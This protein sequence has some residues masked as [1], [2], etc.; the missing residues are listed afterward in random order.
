MSPHPPEIPADR[1]LAGAGT[2]APITL[3]ARLRTLAAACLLVFGLLVALAV[4]ARLLF[5]QNPSGTDFVE[6][7]AQG[8]LLAQHA[9]PF[10][11]A[12]TL[13]IEQSLGQN[14]PIPQI[15]FSPPVALWFTLPLGHLSPRAGLNLWRAAQLASLALALWLLWRLNG[16][17]ASKWHLLGFV[18]A[19]VIAC[20]MAAQLSL[21]FLL[22]L[23]VFL[24]H[25]R[26]HPFWAGAVL[27][28][29]ALK[30]HIILPFALVLLLWVVLRRCYWLAAGFVAALAVSCAVSL[31]LAPHCWAQYRKAMAGSGVM[32]VF[33][34]A[35]AC[36]LRFLIDPAAKWIQ[37]VPEICACI[38]ALWY[39]W[40]RRGNWEW[41]RHGMMV[42]MVA[43]ICTPYGWFVD[44]SI[45]LP[46]MLTSV[47]CALQYRRSLLPLLFFN[48]AALAEAL[49]SLNLHSHAYLWTAPAWLAWYLY[50]TR[51]PRRVPEP[52]AAPA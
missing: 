6:Y 31:Y 9:N 47:Y 16:R 27:M 40:T 26:Q 3:R 21:F 34:P 48:A 45:L 1:P 32:D 51:V 49:A 28:P 15:T 23:V 8:R 18:F 37:F 25:H 24:L 13:R 10:D 11:P 38:W 17:P 41:Q 30:P 35:L 36:A 12:A 19:P 7:F 22:C 4:Y 50:A 43:A 52:A 20:Q 5:T 46:A 29:F 2:P 42:L 44:E 33:I 39:F 14:S